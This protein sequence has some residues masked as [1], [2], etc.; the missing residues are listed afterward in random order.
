MLS[1]SLVVGLKSYELRYENKQQKDIRK[2]AP[3]K[4]GLGKIV[5]FGSPM[6]ILN[7]LGDMDVQ[8]YL[9]QIGLEWAGSGYEK[10]DFDKAADLRQEYLEQ[11]EADAGEKY[12][13]L[14]ELLAEAIS[15]NVI[16]A[17]G[18][19]LRAKGEAIQAENAEKEKVTKVEELARIYEARIL[20]EA[21]AKAKLAA[22]SPGT[23]GNE[24]P[25]MP[26]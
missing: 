4:F 12:E 24:K 6:D 14:Q 19:K 5:Q 13:A 22:E 3:K 2:N 7:F 8:T 9:I 25:Q 15:L 23:S 26:V 11:G 10:I 1:T 21:R 17:S 18:K 20:A 16:G